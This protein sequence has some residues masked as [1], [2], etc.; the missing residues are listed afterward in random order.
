MSSVFVTVGSTRFD[1]LIK[2]LLSPEIVGILSGDLGVSNLVLQIGSSEIGEVV[3]AIGELSKKANLSVEFYRYKESILED[4]R[5]AD[6]VICHAGAGSCLEI[7]GEGKNP[8]VVVNE[9]LMN[10]HQ[11]ELALKLSEEGYVVKTCVSQLP[12]TLKT[13]RKEKLKG[14]PK[15]NLKAF[16]DHID[17]LF[18]I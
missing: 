4:I 9:S 6:W 10:N 13:F 7:L 15:G 1:S 8:L 14:Y 3:G 16:S 2:S 5:K 17:S 12:Q 11:T 18:N